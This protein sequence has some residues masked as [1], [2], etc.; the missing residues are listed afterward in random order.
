MIVDTSDQATSRDV[1]IAIE[2]IRAIQ[3]EEILRVELTR[4]SNHSGT[5]KGI[6]WLNEIA[7]KLTGCRWTWHSPNFW[8]NKHITGATTSTELLRSV[9]IERGPD[10]HF[11]GVLGLDI[12]GEHCWNPT[13]KLVSLS[14]EMWLGYLWRLP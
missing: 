14:P 5:A 8:V 12:F 10:R 7:W 11:C 1:T 13:V 2:V 6:W 3:F 4:Q 9:L